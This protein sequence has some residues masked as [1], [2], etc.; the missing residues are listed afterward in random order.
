[1]RVPDVAPDDIDAGFA[2]TRAPSVY[3]VEIDGEAVLLDEAADRLHLM[4]HTATLLWKLFDGH[5]T[6]AVLADE[7]SRELD[8]SYETVADDILSITRHLGEEG[9]LHGVTPADE[10]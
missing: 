4:N 9:L 8:A 1:V 7:L 10:P 3:E 6:I 5:T 2:P